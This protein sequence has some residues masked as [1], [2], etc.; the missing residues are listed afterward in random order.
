MKNLNNIE[1]NMLIHKKKMNRRQLVRINFKTIR[2]II[3][4]LII[5]RHNF[6]LLKSRD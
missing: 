1:M 3:I 5:F 4:K 2:I 6:F